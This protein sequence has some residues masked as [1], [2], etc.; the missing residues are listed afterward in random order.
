MKAGDEWKEMECKGTVPPP[1]F[2]HTATLIGKTRVV[3]FGGAIEADHK[4]VMTNAVYV[5][6]VYKGEWNRLVGILSHAY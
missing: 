1:S 4:Y 5:F 2:G 6:S 3:L